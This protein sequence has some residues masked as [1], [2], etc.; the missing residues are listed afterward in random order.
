MGNW[1]SGLMVKQRSH[2]LPASNGYVHEG[3]VNASTEDSPRYVI[4]VNHNGNWIPGEL[5]PDEGVAYICDGGAAHRYKTYEVLV[6]CNSKWVKAS[7]G[8]IDKAADAITAGVNAH[9]DFYIGRVKHEGHVR[10][11]KVVPGIGCIIPD[12]EEELVLQSYEVL[13]CEN[14]ILY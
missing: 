12:G 5:I 10:I 2:W 7:K 1:L 6:D 13:V 3:A 8:R 14:D 11:G 9:R 4:R